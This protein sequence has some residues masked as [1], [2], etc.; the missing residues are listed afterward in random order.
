MA[1]VELVIRIPEED[2]HFV[3]KQVS[4]G[5][6]N[7][8]KICIAQ[9]VPLPKG[10]GKLID[11]DRTIKITEEIYNASSVKDII[12]PGEMYAI[13]K[14]LT[15]ATAII[16]AE[17]MMPYITGAKL[18]SAKEAR[19]LDKEILKADKDWWLG[20]C[21]HFDYY[22]ACVYGDDSYVSI[23][24][25]NVCLSCGVRPALEI[26]NL[27]FSIYQIG[28]AFSFGDHSFTVISEK[29]ALCN[30]MIGE[31]AFRKD[32]EVKGS[33]D[34]EVSDIKKFVDDW[35]AKAKEQAKDAD[36]VQDDEEKEL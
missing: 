35:F 17:D 11:A 6:T 20:S 13:R 10:H 21:G 33:N 5:I 19:N 27:N 2:Y 7:P 31:C 29:Y 18:L 14:T 1:D 8:L 4:D 23:Y 9:G 36:K 26:S 3:K 16:E 22:A 15:G 12:T 34:Y 30:D 32:W 25:E 24:G 28:D